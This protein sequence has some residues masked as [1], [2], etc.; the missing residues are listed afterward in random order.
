MRIKLKVDL[1]NLHMFY[2]NKP[3]EP[4]EVVEDP[5]QEEILPH[6]GMH[7]SNSNLEVSY[8]EPIIFGYSPYHQFEVDKRDT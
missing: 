5:T 6:M 8:G 7:A 2:D 4:I 1:G 3:P